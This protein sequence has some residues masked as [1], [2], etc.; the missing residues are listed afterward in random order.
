MVNGR[1]E[2][3]ICFDGDHLVLV[4]DYQDVFVYD[5][6]TDTKGPVLTTD[7]DSVASTTSRSR[8]T[9]TCW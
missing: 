3:D 2:S 9:I 1:G 5:I 7:R 4:G 6:S 8:R